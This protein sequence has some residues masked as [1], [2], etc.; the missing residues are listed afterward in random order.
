MANDDVLFVVVA[1]R[2]EM[3]R[4]TVVVGASRPTIMTSSESPLAFRYDV[5]INSEDNDGG[6]FVLVD[7]S[8]TTSLPI[9]LSAVDSDDWRPPSPVYFRFDVAAGRSLPVDVG[10]NRSDGDDVIA[11]AGSAAGVVYFVD[12][13][14][15]GRIKNFTCMN[16]LN[17]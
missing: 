8:S 16:I 1:D 12:G 6:F 5:R 15:Q 7:S 14:D 3:N 4:L 2:P 17:Y 9:L 13:D 11:S 10:E